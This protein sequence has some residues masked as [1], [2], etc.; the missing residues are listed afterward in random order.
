MLKL[1]D[2]VQG[3]MVEAIDHDHWI[4]SFEG[5]LQQV[6]NTTALKFEKDRYIILKVKEENPL[7]LQIYSYSSKERHGLALKV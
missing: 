4:I 7:Q 1:G 5:K 3:K 6:K 2:I